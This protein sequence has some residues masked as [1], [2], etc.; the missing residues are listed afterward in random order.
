MHEMRKEGNWSRQ[1]KVWAETL[2][3]MDEGD[4]VATGGKAAFHLGF[5]ISV[6]SFL[7]L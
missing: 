4:P 7:I 6:L 5:P 1:I 2:K 3:E